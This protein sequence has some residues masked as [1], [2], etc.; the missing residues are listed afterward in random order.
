MFARC[1]PP[2]GAAPP[3]PTLPGPAPGGFTG[4]RTRTPGPALPVPLPPPLQRNCP[5]ARPRREGAARFSQRRS[6]VVRLSSGVCEW[7]PRMGVVSSCWAKAREAGRPWGWRRSVSLGAP[8]ARHR[9]AVG[10][11]GRRVV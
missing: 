9:G 4:A 10:M 3:R 11:E 6:S 1:P 2:G 5:E 7:L 8:Q